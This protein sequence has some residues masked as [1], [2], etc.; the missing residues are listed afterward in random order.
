MLLIV[1]DDIAVQTSL[2]LL[3]Q[4]EGYAV[5]T[6]ASPTEA[7]ALTRQLTAIQLVILDL[8]YSV[9][10]SGVE[11]MEALKKFKTEF[12]MLPIIV[13]TGWGTIDLAVQ[14]MRLGAN[15]FLT[16]PWQN[17]QLLQSVR[18][19]LKLQQPARALPD[20]KALDQ[21][22]QLE[23]IIGEDAQLLDLLNTVGRVAPTDAAVLITG[24][25]GTGKELIAEAIHVNSKR[26]QKSFVKVN[27]GGISATLFESELF[28]HVRGA[29]TDAKTDRIGR[30]ELANK[31]SIFL[32]E[33]GD[34]D[35]ASQVKLLRVLQDR[36]FE[37]LG[38]SRSKNADV[39]VIC[40]TNR[41]LTD[42]V[43]KGTFRE[44]LFYRIN[45]ITL[46]LPPLRER[47]GDIPLLAVFF[48]DNLKIIYERPRLSIQPQALQWLKNLSLPGNIR[49]LK[50]L[51]ERTVLL[52]TGDE[53]RIAD[54]QKNWQDVH[55]GVSN[56][57]LPAV[58]T[59]TL[60]AMEL[61]M[62]ERAMAFHQN[63]LSKVARSLGITRFALYRRLEKYG[64]A[65][66]PNA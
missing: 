2:A 61:A 16:K 59:M 38:S 24:E 42:M 50:N 14:G 63:K 51:V 30:F 31:G 33:I 15:D 11:G 48:V 10:T 8:N 25:S 62:I 12:P 64:I 3:L 52:S 49:Q 41:D 43:A 23:Q 6:A 35:L 45:L 18:T 4:Q 37:P 1:D 29:F 54:F 32:D 5:K 17:E 21:Q 47:P 13:L 26:Q 65:Y 27:L 40:A 53:L 9:E 55:N 34:L 19:L 39:R 22:Y 7:L 58:G 46:H 36:T 66:D 20:R 57:N 56:S 28:G 60:E 44:D